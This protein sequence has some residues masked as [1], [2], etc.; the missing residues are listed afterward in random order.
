MGPKTLFEN[1]SRAGNGRRRKIGGDEQQRPLQPIHEEIV[2]AAVFEEER[3][4]N[5]DPP[6]PEHAR[7]NPTCALA[8][9]HLP[10]RERANEARE[11]EEPSD[12]ETEKKRVVVNGDA[13][14]LKEL[15]GHDKAAECEDDLEHEGDEEDRE[16]RAGEFSW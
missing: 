3:K 5:A 8:A 12:D 1:S 9:P 6:S 13:E 14:L 16:E 7:Q 4:P 10:R 11:S 15:R 2:D